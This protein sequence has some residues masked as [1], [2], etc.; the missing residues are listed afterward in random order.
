MAKLKGQRSKS[1]FRRSGKWL[2]FRAYKKKEQGNKDALTQAPL[3]SGFQ[4]HHMNQ[5]EEDY[6]DLSDPEN[7]VALNRYSHKLLHYFF[8]YYKKDRSVLQ[9]LEALMERML[10]FNSQVS[11]VANSEN[12]ANLRNDASLGSPGGDFD[13]KFDANLRHDETYTG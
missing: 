2:K 11:Q 9:R 13:A 12:D 5:H 7:F 4:V 8:T 6:E 3:H 1:K 10:R